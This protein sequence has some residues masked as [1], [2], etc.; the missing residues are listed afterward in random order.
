MNRY[1]ARFMGIAPCVFDASTNE[2]FDIPGW[3]LLFLAVNCMAK[4]TFFIE[5]FIGLEPSFFFRITRPIPDDEFQKIL[6]WNKER[7]PTR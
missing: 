4:I 3:G 6:Q 5:S 2:T 1:Y 7:R